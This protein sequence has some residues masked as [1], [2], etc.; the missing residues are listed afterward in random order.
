MQ[1]SRFLEEAWA[2]KAAPP[3]SNPTNL[4]IPGSLVPVE[5][6]SGLA[7]LVP[8]AATGSLPP[9]PPGP[10]VWDHL[11]Y[12][13]L[14]ENT[15]AY[16][17][18][19]R[20]LEEYAFGE[21]L[22]V[23]DPNVHDWLRTTE[24]LFYRDAPPFQIYS[25]T[26]WI[27]PDARAM[28]RNVYFRMFGMDLNHG[29]DDNRP[30]PYP[31][32]RAANTEFVAIFEEFLREV[33]RA[34][35]NFNN[36][37]GADPTDDAAIANLARAL[38]DMLLVRRRDGNLAR[39][40]LAYVSMMSW[41]HLSLGLN[42]PIVQALKAEASSPEDRLLKIGERVGLPAHSRAGAYFR[43]ADAMSLILRAIE[44][45]A[46]NTEQTAPLLYQPPPGGAQDTMQA[47][48]RDWTIATGR[49]MK[50]RKVSVSAPQ[51]TPIAAPPRPMIPASSN[52]SAAG[53]TRE[54]VPT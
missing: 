23:P 42:S 15:R 25:L 32:A 14:I 53:A 47:I 2:A 37:S 51:P 26:S 19:R 17:I 7:T 41:F 3:F 11:I 45:A 24:Q 43:L 28:R 16:E 33:W 4:E 1:L 52:G 6:S 20:V 21:T 9:A 36:Q 13:Y 35:E 27:R 34:I 31:R 54:S 50:A 29:T 48:I 8:V 18:F 39:E 49:D 40:E 30:Y 5:R 46:F 38:H 44:T 22:S 10:V 12:A